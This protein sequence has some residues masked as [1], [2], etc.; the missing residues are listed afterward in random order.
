MHDRTRQRVDVAGSADL[1]LV[2]IDAGIFQPEVLRALSDRQN[3]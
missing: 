1:F 2:L 3:H